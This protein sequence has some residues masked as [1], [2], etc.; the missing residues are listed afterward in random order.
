L[1]GEREADAGGFPL[2]IFSH[3]SGGLRYQSFF[4]TELLASHGFVVVA[5]GHV[6]NTVFDFLS[7]T[8]VDLLQTLID[9]P[10][11][12][13]FLITRMLEKNED[14]DDPFHR[15]IDPSRIAVAGHSLGGFTSLAIAGG[16]GPA[17]LEQPDGEL[18][19]DF[20]PIP[21]D[22][23]VRAIVPMAPVSSFLSDATLASIELPTLILGGTLDAT[24]PIDPESTRAFEL[25]GARRLYRVDIEGAPHFAFSDSCAILQAFVD[26]GLPA[27]F[28][29]SLLGEEFFADFNA[30]CE[31]E[32]LEV[33]EAHRL[34]NLYAVAFLQRFLNRDGRYQRLLTESYAARFEPEV[35]LFVKPWTEPTTPR[36]TLGLL[37]D[38]PSVPAH[39]Q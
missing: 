24:T 13:S 2:A 25:L 35:A 17:D 32:V 4:F 12:V 34:T 9:R 20:E 10:Q 22:S 15:R 30:P 36:E 38:G 14:P 8:S 23:R 11:D 27:S 19:P 29:E 39:A 21:P 26:F 5:P 31:E 33:D 28:L 7:A 6:G 18:P 3:G 37:G 1:R 16:F